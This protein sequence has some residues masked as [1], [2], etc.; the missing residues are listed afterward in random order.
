MQCHA[1]IFHQLHLRFLYCVLE[2]RI[3]S[4]QLCPIYVMTHEMERVRKGFKWLCD[5]AQQEEKDEGNPEDKEWKD[6]PASTM[7]S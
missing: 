7:H 3:L 5:K 2:C 1:T 6:H 4:L